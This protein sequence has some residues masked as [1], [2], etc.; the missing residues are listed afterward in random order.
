[1]PNDEL[2]FLQFLQGF[3][4]GD[5]VHKADARMAELMNAIHE[6]GGKGKLV[7]EL[8]F[9]VNKAGQIE[10]NPKIKVDKPLRPVG[11]GIFYMTDE[12]RLS[13]RDPAQLDMMDEFETRRDRD[14]N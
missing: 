12:A 8:P 4:R 5:L 14:V 3:R 10:C 9:E 2:N 6:T 7:L 11:T 13:R 1:M